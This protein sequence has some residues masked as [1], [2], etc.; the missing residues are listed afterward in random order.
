MANAATVW[1]ASRGSRP[2]NALNGGNVIAICAS[3]PDPRSDAESYA[4]D[5][6]RATDKKTYVYCVELAQIK[7]FQI[8]KEVITFVPPR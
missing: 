3:G 5:E 8:Y 6:T 2:D 4:R 7:G 1:V